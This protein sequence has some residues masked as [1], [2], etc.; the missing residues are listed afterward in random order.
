M[1]GKKSWKEEK[2]L[3]KNWKKKELN[4]QINHIHLNTAILSQWKAIKDK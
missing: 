1:E 2:K 3:K 4:L